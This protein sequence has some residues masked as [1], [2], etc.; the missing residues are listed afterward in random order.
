MGSG[1]GPE[2]AVKGPHFCEIVGA[3]VKVNLESA[4]IKS[5]HCAQHVM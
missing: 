5:R 3:V 4:V 1:F 2:D